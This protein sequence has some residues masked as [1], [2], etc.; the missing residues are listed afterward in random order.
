MKQLSWN[1]L[2]GNFLPEM[3]LDFMPQDQLKKY[4]CSVSR[5]SSN[6]P[7]TRC[8]S[9]AAEWKKNLTPDSIRTLEDILSFLLHEKDLRDTYPFG[10]FAVDMSEVVRLHALERHHRQAHRRRLLVRNRTWMYGARVVKRG[11]LACGFTRRD[12]VRI[13][14]ATASSQAA[15]AFTRR[16]RS[17]RRDRHSISGGNTGDQVVFIRDFGVTA[18]AGTPGLLCTHHRRRR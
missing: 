7:M 16:F 18:I 9:S 6:S 3:A 2:N 4:S 12:I 13:S 17:A 14:S 5:R 11:L 15:S 1:D 8:L 10:L